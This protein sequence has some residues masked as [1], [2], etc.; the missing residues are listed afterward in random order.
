MGSN[1]SDEKLRRHHF[2][3]RIKVPLERGREIFPCRAHVGLRRSR[4]EMCDKYSPQE[5]LRICALPSIKTFVIENNS[6]FDA[7]MWNFSKDAF[8]CSPTEK[9]RTKKKL[10]GKLLKFR[11]VNGGF[12]WDYM[13]NK[14]SQEVC[15]SA[16]V[17]RKIVLSNMLGDIR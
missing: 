1:D 9:F 6:T 17:N 7:V 14:P 2:T 8:G 12:M 5:V 16:D 4:S 15:D 3:E 13:R 11:T 10:L